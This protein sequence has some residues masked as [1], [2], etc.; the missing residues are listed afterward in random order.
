MTSGA[1]DRAALAAFSRSRIEK[2]SK[3]F[4]VASR[5]FDVKTRDAVHMLY[6]WCRHCD[7][8]I[9]DQD[10]GFARRSGAQHNT[11]DDILQ[12]LREN[13]RAA[14]AGEL[15]EDP[16]FQ[17]L[18]HV[19]KTYA[20]PESQPLDHITGF[21]MDVNE[22]AYNT[23][24]DT[25][26]YCYHVA[27]VVGIMMARIMG[28]QGQDTLERACDLG[29]AFQLT[30]ICR[31]VIDDARIG[32]VY[33][34]SNWLRD[35]GLDIENFARTE[36]RAALHKVVIRTLDLADRYYDSAGVGIARLPLRAAGAIAAARNVYRDIGEEVRQGGIHAWDTRAS[37]TKRQ[38]MM[39]AAQGLLQ[40]MASRLYA[41]SFDRT[42]LWT[43]SHQ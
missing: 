21:E 1:M 6:A 22:V 43:R 8:V 42:G 12:N 41:P 16:V 13:T 32:R 25:L 11:L 28:V 3:S 23:I 5:I 38:K 4:A 30:N 33:L 40:A 24:E 19:T 36:N 29:I 15:P 18:A 17:S 31:D 37:T 35:V 2:G 39:R 7:D 27:G 26:T 34:P 20:I 9:D 14:L 10:L